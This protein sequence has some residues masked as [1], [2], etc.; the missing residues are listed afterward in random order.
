L[1][2]EGAELRYALMLLGLESR[3][4]EESI[5]ARSCG[6]RIPSP[7]LSRREKDSF[8]W[9]ICAGLRVLRLPEAVRLRAALGL[10]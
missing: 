7:S 3:P 2:G 8:S 1:K 10:L 4:R 6:D 5:E 9:L